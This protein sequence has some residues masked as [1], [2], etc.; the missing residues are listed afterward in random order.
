MVALALC[1]ASRWCENKE[2]PLLLDKEMSLTKAQP[3]PVENTALF[4]EVPGE[5]HGGVACSVHQ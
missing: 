3:Y 5:V 1:S 2:H 4:S